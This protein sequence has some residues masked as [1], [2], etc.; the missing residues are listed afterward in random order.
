MKNVPDQILEAKRWLQQANP[1]LWKIIQHYESLETWC[2]NIDDVLE[3]GL[4]RLQAAFSPEFFATVDFDKLT[5]VLAHLHASVCLYVMF[6]AARSCPSF[7]GDML[8]HSQQLIRMQTGLA[9][10]AQVMDDRLRRLAAIHLFY[11]LFGTETRTRVLGYL[12]S[13]REGI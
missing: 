13:T 1:E 7:S 10:E 4:E 8:L 5:I 11:K 12:Q 6:Q 9:P 3:N 2:L